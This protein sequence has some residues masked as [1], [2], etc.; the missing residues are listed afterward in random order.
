LKSNADN[1]RNTYISQQIEP[2]ESTFISEAEEINRLLE[3][4]PQPE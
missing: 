1:P 3:G 2:I 4:N